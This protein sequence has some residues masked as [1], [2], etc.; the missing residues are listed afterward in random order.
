MR[1]GEERFSLL[2]KKEEGRIW[3]G[4]LLA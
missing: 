2:F 3:Q 1:E 4:L